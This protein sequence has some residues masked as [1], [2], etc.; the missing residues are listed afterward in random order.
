MEVGLVAV[1][2]FAVPV[3]EDNLFLLYMPFAILT[4]WAFA[5]FTIFVFASAF[6]MFFLIL[7]VNVYLLC[8]KP[9]RAYAYF[10]V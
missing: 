3:E 1:L 8:F 9:V 7:H 2:V 4:L 6:A 5:D 10:D